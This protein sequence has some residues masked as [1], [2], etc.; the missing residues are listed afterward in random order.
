LQVGNGVEV[1]GPIPTFSISPAEYD[2]IIMV[3]TGTGIAPF[4][5]LLS[6][7]TPEKSSH[8]GP[9][10]DLVHLQP[11]SGKEDWAVSGGMI[12]RLEAKFGERLAVHRPPPQLISGETIRSALKQSLDEKERIM[13]L[14]CLPPQYVT[15]H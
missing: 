9:K 5:Q 4:L 14:V 13:V 12:P 1:R 15:F 6:R 7:M 10:L 3:S 2:R 8:G 11:G